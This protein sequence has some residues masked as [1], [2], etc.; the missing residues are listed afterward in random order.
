MISSVDLSSMEMYF[1]NKIVPEVFTTLIV[2]SEG[3]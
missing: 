1:L 2:G 3:F